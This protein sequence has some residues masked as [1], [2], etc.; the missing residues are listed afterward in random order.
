MAY[1]HNDGNGSLFQN[2]KENDNQPDMTGSCKI[3][4]R[5]WRV[6]AWLKETSRGQKMFSLK[7]S[8]PRTSG[9][10]PPF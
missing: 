7:F 6:A 1:E 9:G 3:D 5:V 2:K 4:G 8:E 10:E